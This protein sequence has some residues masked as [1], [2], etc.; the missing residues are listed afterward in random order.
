LSI[1]Y[2]A[3]QDVPGNSYIGP[4]GPAGLKGHPAHGKGGRA[5]R[6]PDTARRLWT[7]TE[8]LLSRTDNPTAAA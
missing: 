4:R 2:A 1:L 6:H 8:M 5:G 3:T 7:A